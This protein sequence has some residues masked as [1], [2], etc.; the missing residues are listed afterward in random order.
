MALQ[1]TVGNLGGA[2]GSNIYLSREA[3][4]Y[5]T[6]Y[7]VSL[8]V[9]VMAIIAGIILRIKLKAINAE[10]DKMTTEEI[11]AR[12]TPAQLADMGD[13]SPLFRYTL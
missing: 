1:L 6:G 4:R 12:Y 2:V 5:W 8:G 11:Y 13:K 7:G 10:R 3:P 9:L